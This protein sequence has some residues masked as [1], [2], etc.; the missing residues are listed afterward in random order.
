M[1]TRLPGPARRTPTAVGRLLA[2]NFP[3]SRFLDEEATVGLL[4]R[5]TETGTAGG[6]VY[7]ALVAAAAAHH[8]VPLATR[9][10]RA[11]LTYRAFDV[12]VVAIR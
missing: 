11:L 10:T 3:Y 8:Q 12:E 4:G 9:D 6:A 7:D 1:L 5:L 2:A